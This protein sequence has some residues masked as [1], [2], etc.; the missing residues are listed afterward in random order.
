MIKNQSSLNTYFEHSFN[1]EYW[2]NR[3][4]NNE[5]AWDIGYPSPAITEYLDQ[6]ENKNASILIPGCG[7]AYEAEY[8]IKKGFSNITLIDISPKVV[9]KLNNKFKS[10]PE[11]KILCVDFFTHQAK[12]DLFIEQTFFCA[13]PPS[14]RAEYVSHASELLNENGKIIGVLFNKEFNQ[15]N[16]PFGGCEAEYRELFKPFFNIKKMEDCYN[17]ILPRKNSEF[18]INLIKK[19]A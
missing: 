8:L 7:N 17:S 9:E 19:K 1:K 16:P 13:I 2:E 5:T 15:P 3:W 14:K 18:F 11:I 6:F 4:L 10:I 12:Y